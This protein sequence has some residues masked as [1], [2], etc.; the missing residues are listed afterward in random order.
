MLERRCL[1]NLID[2]SNHRTLSQAVHA[3]ELSVHHL[4]RPTEYRSENDLRADCIYHLEDEAERIRRGQRIDHHDVQ[5][6]E[7]S[8]CPDPESYQHCWE[9]GVDLLKKGLYAE[10]L[11]KALS[12]LPNCKTLGVSDDGQPWGAARLT[13]YLAIRPN[14]VITEVLPSSM[15]HAFAVVRLLIR[16]MIRTDAP[17]EKIYIDFGHSTEGCTSVVPCMLAI[18]PSLATQADR[19]PSTITALRLVINPDEDV[20]RSFWG[21]LR[22]DRSQP[23]W[24]SSFLSF[25]AILPALSDLSLIFNLADEVYLPELSKRLRVPRLQSLHLENLDWNAPGFLV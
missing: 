9:D 4:I 25:I 7:E 3:V 10:Y 14:R 24:L 13:R 5:D 15:V 16:A 20:D 17:L 19:R 22:E 21:A 12:D 2:I 11:F 6:R 18:P 8:P 1:L 23:N